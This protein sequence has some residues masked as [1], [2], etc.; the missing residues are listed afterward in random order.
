MLSLQCVM[1]SSGNALSQEESSI[2]PTIGADYSSFLRNSQRMSFQQ[3]LLHLRIQEFFAVSPNDL[4]NGAVEWIHNGGHRGR[5]SS[6][7][8]APLWSIHVR[9]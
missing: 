8:S 6:Q 3:W 5:H 2:S 7:L 1:T 4:P 9:R